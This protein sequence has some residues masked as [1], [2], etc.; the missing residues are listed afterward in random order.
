MCTGVEIFLLAS[1]AA[2][3]AVAA[4]SQIQQ[5]R[6]E[7]KFRNFQSEQAEADAQAEREAGAVRA[8]QIRKGYRSQ[9]SEARS[10]LA[11]G[12]VEV[13]AGTALVIDETIARRGE[14]DAL[15]EILYG[16]RRGARLDQESVGLRMA[17]DNAQTSGYMGA[18]GTILGGGAQVAKGWKGTRAPVYDA[19]QGGSPVRVN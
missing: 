16:G 13:G 6:Q 12:G 3:T 5:A 1:A 2:S 18:F 15:Q 14:E 11:A 8:D 4:G 7:K 17:G 19:Q 10:A 9:Q